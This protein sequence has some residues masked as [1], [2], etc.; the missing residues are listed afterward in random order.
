MNRN[1]AIRAH[2][3]WK[4]RLSAY[5]RHPDGSLNLSDVERDDACELGE[6]IKGEGR[7]EFSGD[8]AFQHLQVAHAR[9]HHCAA[10]IV[11]RADTG[12]RASEAKDLGVHGDLARASEEVVTSLIALPIPKGESRSRLAV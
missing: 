8:M 4:K 12:A 11:R 2:A 3:E 10:G 6:W 9:F 1:E 5:L 7:A